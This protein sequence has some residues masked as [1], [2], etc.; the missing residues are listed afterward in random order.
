[1]VTC[2]AN[3]YGYLYEILVFRTHRVLPSFLLISHYGLDNDGILIL[4]EATNNVQRSIPF[5]INHVN[6]DH[7]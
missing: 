1:M 6:Q 7:F 3:Q 2:M 5:C 4:Y